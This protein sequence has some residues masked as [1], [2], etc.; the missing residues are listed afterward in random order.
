MSYVGERKGTFTTDD[1]RQELPGFG[2]MDL[3]A[4]VKWEKWEIS[5]YANNALDKRGLLNGGI[6]SF[7]PQGFFYI[8]PRTVGGTIAK[9]F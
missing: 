8:Q 3:R 9:E 2:K 7:N 6:G 5:V 4:G 1:V